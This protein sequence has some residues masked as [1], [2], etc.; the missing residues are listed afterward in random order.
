MKHARPVLF[1]SLTDGQHVMVKNH[2][3][4]TADESYEGQSDDRKLPSSGK[5]PER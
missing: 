3:A 4:L 2:Y 5:V 1:H